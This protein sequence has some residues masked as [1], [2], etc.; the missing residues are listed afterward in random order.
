MKLQRINYNWQE[1]R[2]LFADD[3]HF[4]HLLIS[5]VFAHT[6]VEII[7]AYNGRQAVELARKYTIDLAI[8]D[9][10][11]PYMNGY[12]V[13]S[14]IKTLHQDIKCIAYTAD[15]IRF[16]FTRSCEVGF[17]KVLFKPVLPVVVLKSVDALLQNA[18]V[19]L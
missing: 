3:E 8:I 16:D 15:Q 5:K 13:V 7:H 1:T 14:E 4:C 11:M 17:D 2:I 10:I 6:G 12:E 9:I 19:G 18:K